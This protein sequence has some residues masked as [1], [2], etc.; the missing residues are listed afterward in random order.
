MCLQL[1]I[2]LYVCIHVLYMHAPIVYY[3]YY[4]K[5]LHTLDPIV[6]LCGRFGL[7]V[8]WMHVVYLPAAAVCA[9]SVYCSSHATQLYTYCT[10]PLLRHVSHN[11][12]TKHFVQN[13]QC[14]SISTPLMQ[15]D[16]Y[17]FLWSSE[18]AGVHLIE[19]SVATDTLSRPGWQVS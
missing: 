19:F 16:K 14:D 4:N 8:H 11:R 2:I 5:C 10:C 17:Q 6:Q 3:Y 18:I 1:H 9:L 12:Q 7:Y 15:Y 13:R